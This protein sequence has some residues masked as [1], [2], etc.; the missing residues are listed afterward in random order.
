MTAERQNR[1]VVLLRV[2]VLAATQTDGHLSGASRTACVIELPFVVLGQ[3]VP[4]LFHFTAGLERKPHFRRAGV[5]Q[6][7]SPESSEGYECGRLSVRGRLHLRL[8]T[9]AQL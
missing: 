1:A 9:I 7:Q 2:N 3:R 8:F 5:P 4:Q 6:D